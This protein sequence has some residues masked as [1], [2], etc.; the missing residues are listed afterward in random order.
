MR[1]LFTSESVT[2]GHPDKMCDQISDAILDSIL[3]KDP[4][5]R[6]ACETC[7]TTGMVMVMGEITTNCYVDIPKVVRETVRGIGYDRAKFGF[8][9]DTCSVLTSID[10]Q[11]ADIAMGV[12][13]AFES[14]KGEKDEV[15]AVGAGDQGMMFGFATNETEDYMPLPIYM[16]H[17]LSRRLTEVRKDKTLEYLRP[18]GKTQVTVE[19]EDNQPKRIDTIVISTQHDEKI[20]LEQ[21]QEDLKKYVIDAVVPAELLDSE[22]RYFINPTGRF[23]VGGP[24]G[25]SGLTGRKIIVDTYGG[26]GRHGGGAFSGKDPTKVDRSAAYAARW[27]AK[28]LVAAGVA[29]KLEIQV[30]YA[31]G[32]AK[33]VSIEVETFGTGKVSEEKIVEI[34]EKVF[35]LRPGAIIRDLDLRR[36]IYKQTAAYGHFGRNDLNLP[37]EQLNKVDEIKKYL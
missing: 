33:P 2:E 27:V 30:A 19:Y 37:W 23:V 3:E 16:A 1:R 26:Y 31:I 35:D 9:C 29:D 10:E 22:T 21:I 18:D 25:D 14:K 34:V 4:N 13:E 32:V 11:S 7:T 6:V 8:D 28:N 12:D 24:Q 17:K 15:E 5:A 20:S 36:P